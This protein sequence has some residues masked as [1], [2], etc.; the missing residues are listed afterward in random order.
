[1]AQQDMSFHPSSPPSEG[2]ADSYNHEGTPDTRLTTFSPLEDS[3]KSSRLLSTLT[4]N[5]GKVASHP[6]KF[7]V[8]ST[9]HHATS[10]DCLDS[11]VLEKDPFISSSPEK[12]QKKLSATASSFQPLFATPASPLV[13]N[14]SNNLSTPRPMGRDLASVAVNASPNTGMPVYTNDHLSANFSFDLNL[15]RSLR[16]T[17]GTEQLSIDSICDY[18]KVRAPLLARER[19]PFTDP[20]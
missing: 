14:G 2:G 19:P 10:N 6:V 11:S 4:L 7:E 16:I 12:R 17:C 13:A 15:S 1:M 8:P 9:I 20:E 5:T 18:F 3:T